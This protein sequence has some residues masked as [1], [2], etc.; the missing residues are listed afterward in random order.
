MALSVAGISPSGVSSN[1]SEFERAWAR[2]TGYNIF[3]TFPKLI[4]DLTSI[5]VRK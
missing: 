1:Q 5:S 3:T 2:K 4:F